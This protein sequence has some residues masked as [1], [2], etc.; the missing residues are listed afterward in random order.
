[1]GICYAWAICKHEPL[2]TGDIVLEAKNGLKLGERGRARDAL[3]LCLEL[4][5]VAAHVLERVD[6]VDHAIAHIV[7]LTQELLCAKLLCFGAPV[8]AKL[9]AQAVEKGIRAFVW[10]MHLSP[11]TK[12]GRFARRS[13]GDGSQGLVLFQ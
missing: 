6:K 5:L 8:E 7:N 4:R 3:H 10:Q 13:C 11:S 1:M 9:L 12:Q 2:A